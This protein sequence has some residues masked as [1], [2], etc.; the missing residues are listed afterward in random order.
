[1][2]FLQRVSI[3]FIFTL[4]CCGLSTAQAED[5]IVAGLVE[6][7]V[8]EVEF[9]IGYSEEVPELINNNIES[10]DTSDFEV[11]DNVLV[12]YNGTGGDVTIPAG[13]TEIGEYAFDNCINLTSVSIPDSV[14]TIGSYAFSGCNRLT[15][16]TIPSKLRTT[17]FI[18]CTLQQPLRPLEISGFPNRGCIFAL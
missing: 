7:V 6:N 4:L 2:R 14:T 8:P 17:D 15:N 1:M 3:L 16:L 18:R 9:S 11:V 12:K 10:N 5:E 13:V